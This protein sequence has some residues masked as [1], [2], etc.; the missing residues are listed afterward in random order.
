MDEKE[1]AA[2][3]QDWSDRYG[4]ENAVSH[5]IDIMI[6]NLTEEQLSFIANDLWLYEY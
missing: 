2:D 4:A 6:D 3:I 1:F 5:L